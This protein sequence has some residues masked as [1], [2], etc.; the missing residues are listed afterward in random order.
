MEYSI[1]NTNLSRV[2]LD[3][4]RDLESNKE[5]IQE[6]LKID[7][8]YCKIRINVNDLKEIVNRFQNEKLDIKKEQ[9]ILIHYNGNPYITI[10]LS[11]LSILTKT[12]LVLE[13]DE[14]MLGVNKF[15]VQTINNVLKNIGTDELVFIAS[16]NTEQNVDKI[17]CIDDI[18][19]YNMYLH[20]KNSKAKFYAL[21]YMD[22]YSDS[23]NY[24]EIRSLIYQY[25]E[26]NLIPIESYSE[27]QVNEAIRM[28]KKGNGIQII[29]LTDNKEIIEKFKININNKKIYVNKNPFEKEMKLIHKDIFYI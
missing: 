21:N 28:I 1:N 25:C 7:Y 18:N 15:I 24:E 29:L 9:K 17:I 22:F 10:N 3:I 16:E 12:T 6:L 19:R 5:N 20:K 11:I 14:N 8:K 2:F 26:N 23:D 13:F 4:V 27:F